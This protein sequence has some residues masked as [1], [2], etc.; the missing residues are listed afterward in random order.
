MNKS[1]YAAFL[2]GINVGG[3]RAVS[4]EELKR[5]FETLGFTSVRTVLASGNVL[6]QAPPMPP[7]TIGRRIEKALESRFGMEIGVLVRPVK[8]LEQL[9]A[10]DP[11]RGIPLTAQTR[12]YVTFLP[13]RPT[14]RR[15]HGKPPEGF[16]ILRTARGEVLSAL[17][18]APGIGTVDLMQFLQREFGQ[19]ITTRSYSTVLRLLKA[20]GGL[21]PAGLRKAVRHTPTATSRTAP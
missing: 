16:R 7:A 13:E 10:S 2:R 21:P 1:E 4:M 3:H 17:T 8:K 20:R 6:F 15:I 18:L 5:S 12:L 9:A 14:A 19:G 11:F